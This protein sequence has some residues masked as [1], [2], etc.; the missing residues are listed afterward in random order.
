MHRNIRLLAWHNFFTDFRLYGPFIVIYFADV[1]GSYTLA[2]AVFS[3]QMVTAVL[4]EIPTGIL[5]DRI[6]RKNTLLAGS[7]FSVLAITA[8]ASAPSFWFLALG[9]VL[10][11]VSRSLFTGNNNALIFDSAR[12]AGTEDQYHHFLGRTSSLFQLALGISAGLGGV[13]LL[14]TSLKGLVILSIAPQLLAVITSLLVREPKVHKAIADNALDHLKEAWQHFRHQRKL[15]LLAIAQSVA[16]GFGEASYQFVAAYY[17]TLWPLWA[18]GLLRSAG[19]GLATASFW[20]SGSLIDRFGHYAIMIFSRIYSFVTN[21]VAVALNSLMSPILMTSNSML[22]GAN[23]VASDHL[24][25]QTFSDDHRATLG[26]LASFMGGLAYA[27]AALIIGLIA[28]MFD[29]RLAILAAAVGSLAILP[30]YIQLLRDKIRQS[31]RN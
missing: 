31:D 24:L 2:M 13:L 15:R 14:V 12:E 28:D 6:G 21:A 3:V 29:P 1:S 9:A 18:I 22:F 26:S 25:Q 4:L 11:G 5:S 10:E 20:L 27:T 7:V 17:R 19:H 23:T 8:Y 16:F 30:I